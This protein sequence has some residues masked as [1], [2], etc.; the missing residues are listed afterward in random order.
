MLSVT[1]KKDIFEKI[2]KNMNEFW[3]RYHRSNVG[4]YKQSK[5][6][7]K[8]QCELYG[9]S[10]NEYQEYMKE[11]AANIMQDCLKGCK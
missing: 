6:Y 1:T 10:N 11:A 2:A 8:E 4:L 3:K 9:V 7:E 5:I